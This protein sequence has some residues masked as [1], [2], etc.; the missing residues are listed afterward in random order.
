[1]YAG[2]FDDVLAYRTS[3]L[4][5]DTKMWD[6]DLS[7]EE[8]DLICGVYHISTN[9]AQTSDSLWWP[10]HR[11]WMKSGLNVGYWSR[12]CE[13]WFQLCLSSTLNGTAHLKT[14]G[15]WKASL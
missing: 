7:A 11:T 14:V 13:D 9:G 15:E 12:G 8:L 10:K 3:I 6:D 2:P 4:V 5:D 1:V